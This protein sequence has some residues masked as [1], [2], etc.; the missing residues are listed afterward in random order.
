MP[1]IVICGGG[2]VGLSAAMILARDGHEVTVLEGDANPVPPTPASAWEQ[3]DRSGVAQFRQPHNLFPRFRQIL[4][5]ELPGTVDRLVAAGCVWVDPMSRLPP[6]ITDTAP[7]PGDDRFRFVTGRRPVVEA[8]LAAAA[9]EEQGVEVRRGARVAGLRTGPSV[10]DGVPHVTG[11]HLADGTEV[12]ADLVV[13]AMGRRSRLGEWL[14]AVGGRQPYSEAEDCG[15][16]YYTQYFSG[17]ELPVIR[18][19]PVSEVG[20]ISILTLPGDNGTWSVT[21]YAAS[22]DA[23][24]RRLLSP[25]RFIKVLEAFPLHAHWIEGE[26]LTEVLV[27]AGILDRYRRFVINGVPVATGLAAVGD[28][29]A[30]TNPSAGRGMTVGLMHAQRLRDIVRYSLADP[31]AFA[32]AWD[33]ATE[34]DVAPFYWNQIAADRLRVSE[35]TSLR[36]GIDAPPPDPTQQAIAVAA[37][38]DADVFRGVL[39]ARMCLAR[40][41]EVFAR[42]GFMDKVL[43]NR[44][45][46]P[47][48]VPGP[49]RASLLRLLE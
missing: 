4:D 7:R 23:P 44:Q 24:L 41:E 32:L 3:W 1:A 18:A 43:A 20:T 36:T 33:D 2:A 9:A 29:W 39:E 28:A 35:M 37:P 14:G 12:A 47:L 25:D 6:S 42:P 19:A 10:V 15:F 49:D 26:P 5:E 31:A 34:T 40:P 27:M 11:V 17:P 13:D 16:V 46:P 8:A 48:C 45:A 30:C 22:S 38:Y 21:I